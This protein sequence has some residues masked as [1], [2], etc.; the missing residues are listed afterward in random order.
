V[1]IRMCLS[2][3]LM[4]S[5][6]RCPLLERFPLSSR[7][8]EVYRILLSAVTDGYLLQRYVYLGRSYGK[9]TSDIV[10]TYHR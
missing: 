5:M 6:K 8:Y 4:V 9:D 10:Q 1:S 3:E 7:R 2:S